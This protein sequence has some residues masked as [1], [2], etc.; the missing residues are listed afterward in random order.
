MAATDTAGVNLNKDKID[1]L[2]EKITEIV[3]RGMKFSTS[4]VTSRKANPLFLLLRL[5][6]SYITIAKHC[7]ALILLMHAVNAYSPQKFAIEPQDQSAVLGSRVTLP[8]RVINKAGQLQW[9]KD[10]FGLGTHRHLTGYERYKMVGSDEEG[11]YS[12]DISDVTIDDDANYQCQVSTGP[13]GELA[14]R[15]KYARLTVLVPPEPPKILKGPT[16]EAVEDREIMLECVSVGGKPAA[17][18]TWVDSE[19]NVLNQGVT[20]TIEQMSDGRRFIARSVLHLRPRRQHHSHTYTCQA[21]NTADRAYKAASVVLKVQYAPKVRVVVRSRPNGKIQEGDTLVVGCQATANP[22]NVTYKW[23]INNDQVPTARNNELIITNVSRKHNEATIKCEVQNEVGS[24]ADSKSLDVSYGPAFKVKPRNAEGDI[25]SVVTLTCSIEGHPQPKLLWLRYQQDRVIRVGKSSNLTITINKETAGQYWCRASVEGYPDIESPAMVYV[26]G[27]PRIISNQTQY[28]VEGGSVRIECVAF[29]VPKPDYIIWSFGGNEINSF[30]NHE[31]AFLEESLPDGLTKSSLVIRESETKHF[32]SYNCSVSNAYGLDSLEIHLIPDKTMPLIIFVIGG[33]GV[34]ILIL[35]IMLIVMLCHKNSNKKEK[36]ENVTEISKEDKFKDGD[37][38]NISDL[39]LELRQ[40]EVNCEMDPSTGPDLDMRSA[41]QLT[42]NL[43]LP[44]AGAVHDHVYRYSDEFNVHGFKNHDQT[45][46]YVP[47]VDYSRDYAP[48]TNDS[49]TGSLS[50]STDESTYQSHCGSLNRQESCGR[51][52]GLV[53]PDVIP[54]ANSGVVMTGV[55]VRYA[56][57]YG[58]PYL[59]SNGVGY[60]PPVA[61]SSKNAPPP[62]Y[63][64]RNTNQQPSPSMSSS[65]TNSFTSQITS[66]PNNA[67]PQ[68][69]KTPPTTSMYILQNGQNSMNSS[70]ISTKGSGTHV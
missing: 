21:Q 41:L 23:Y 10:D 59:R 35:I 70:I 68:V 36:D 18:I 46:G 3:I 38:S 20:Y 4:R 58:N 61:N 28:G 60:V 50:R 26:K 49:M 37:S 29:S 67:Q 42:S 34:T 33:S 63:T 55:D 57:T 24:S 62:Y 11:D 25:G 27:P 45:K 43:G 16:I 66:L 56:A 14:I 2:E 39:K 47:Y 6:I 64:L 8:C 9:T 22:S 48:P 69:P 12:L 32:G 54:M 5:L 53:G 7:M 52:G 15:S 19:G 40:V 51:L 30:H 1:D 13:K 44:L 17:E 65:I 31:Y